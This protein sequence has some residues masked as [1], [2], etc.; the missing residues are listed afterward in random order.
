MVR[1]AA[2]ELQVVRMVNTLQCMA[3]YRHMHH[4]DIRNNSI[5]SRICHS[6]SRNISSNSSNRLLHRMGAA[7][8][9]DL[10]GSKQQ[11]V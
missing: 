3:D 10:E 9:L 11:M 5:C 1:L 8:R 2:L 4:K 6:S 7:R